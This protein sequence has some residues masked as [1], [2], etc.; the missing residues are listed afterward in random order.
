MD[1]PRTDVPPR[2]SADRHRFSRR[3]FTIRRILRMAALAVCIALFC[4]STAAAQ[5]PRLFRIGTGGRAGVYY[6]LGKLI[7]Q[8]VTGIAKE[9]TG[10]DEGPG[11]MAGFIGVAQSS[12]GSAANLRALAAGEIEAAL[13]QA[14]VAAWAYGA[15]HDFAGEDRLRDL[16]AVASLYPEKLQIVTRGDAGIRRVA[17]MKGKRISIDET[18][19]G[20][21]SAMRIVLEAHGLSEADFAAVYLKPEFTHEKI[22]TGELHGF[23][24]M[25]GIPMEGVS[26]VAGIG[27]RL[28]PIEPQQAARIHSRFPY[29]FPGEIPAGAY[30]GVPATPTLQVHALL[31]V[32]AHMPEETV[33][34]LTETLWSGRT[35][36]LLRSG[37]PQFAAITLESALDGI[38]IP[39]HPGAASFYRAAGLTLKN[40]ETQ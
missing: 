16:R 7:A 37:H 15:R 11:P 28:V 38:S 36:A 19:S 31:V 12:G 1:Q 39:L 33:R 2:Q 5:Q 20:T 18:G 8:A 9:R 25:A 6:P 10:A 26:Q 23:S 22:I 4:G 3:I 27:L 29:L 34:Q 32:M 13:A 24:V 40:I 35:Q 17:D 14:D 30:A 21:L